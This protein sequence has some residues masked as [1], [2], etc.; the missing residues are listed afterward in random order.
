VA[1]QYIFSADA[2]ELFYDKLSSLHD[3]YVYH[4]LLSGVAR[5]GANLESIKMT[6]SPRV[7]RKYCERVVGGLVNLKPEITVKLTE[8]RT[9]RLECFFTKI[10]DD[11]YLN[12]VYMIQNVMDWPQIDNFSCQV[13]YMGETNMKEIKAHWDE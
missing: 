8:D 6:K 13:W 12:H 9:T 3:D 2:K 11:E 5:K 7:N 1:E 4:L 10:N